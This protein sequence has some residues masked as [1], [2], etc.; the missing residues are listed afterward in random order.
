MKVVGL[1]TRPHGVAQAGPA[2]Q[3]FTQEPSLQATVCACHL[4]SS[5]LKCS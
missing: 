5:V 3:H 1:E 2:H 4:E